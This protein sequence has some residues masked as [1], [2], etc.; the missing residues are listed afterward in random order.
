MP[1]DPDAPDPVAA[2]SRVRLW[3]LHKDGRTA[4]C[5]A[6]AHMLGVEIVSEVDGDVRRTEVARTPQAGQALADEE[7]RHQ[8]VRRA[9]A[10]GVNGRVSG[11]SIR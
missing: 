11:R 9:L 10:D 6:Q 7:A 1:L 8:H 2:P 5:D 4:T 3:T